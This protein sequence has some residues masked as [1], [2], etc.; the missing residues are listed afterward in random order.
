M[1]DSLRRTLL[2]GLTACGLAILIQIPQQIYLRSPAS[3]GLPVQL[4]SDE[5]VYIARVEEALNGRG[6]QAAE[7]FIGASN[8]P[9]S[10]TALLERAIGTA[11]RFTG[12]R[13]MTVLQIMDSIVIVG[14]FL[15]LFWFFRLSGFRELPSYFGA[16]AFILIELYNINRPIH[17]G[18]SFCLVLLSLC[19]LLR[20]FGI[21]PLLCQGF[22]G[23]VGKKSIVMGVAGSFLLGILI[24]VYFWAWT[25]AWTWAAILV[26]SLLF[27]RKTEKISG[28]LIVTYAGIA[29]FSGLP[30]IFELL[31]LRRHPFFAEAVFRSGIYYSHLP[32]SWPYSILFALMVIG[33]LMAMRTTDILQKHRSAIV[34]VVTCFILIHQQVI[35]GTVFNF[36]SHYLFAM[37]VAAM[38]MIL[39]V[40]HE[41]ERWLILSAGAACIYLAALAY[42]GRYVIDQFTVLPSRFS[43]QHLADVLPVL[44]QIPRSRILTD[45]DTSMF[46][47][48]FTKHDVVYDLYLKNVLLSHQAIAERYCVT[49]LALPPSEW[50]I[51]ERQHLIYPDANSAFKNDPSVREREVAMVQ[52]ACT[53]LSKDPQ[54]ALQKFG[55]Q[56]V[57]WDKKRQPAWDLKRL[58][59]ALEEVGNEEG[60]LLWKIK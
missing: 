53:R 35:H 55:V 33:V 27:T 32:E 15:L 51:A 36:V 19:F 11:F 12:F 40:W 5:G 31:A 48:G 60:W 22:G 1:S 47:A 54:A 8:L 25:F 16:L 39:L 59:V 7:A 44:D 13:A 23:Q 34:T 42:D 4:N 41:R 38:G 18:A 58:K 56:Y 10:Q 28:R 20:G 29:V 57:L 43:E 52:E 24:G 3:K 9:G 49:Q 14:L 30:A 26:L 45:P 37:A 17:Q 46:I 2:L 6:D 50:K 21:G